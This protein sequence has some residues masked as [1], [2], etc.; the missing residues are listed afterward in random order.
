MKKLKYKK[1]KG[2][3]G[4]IVPLVLLVLTGAFLMIWL[5]PKGVGAS[6]SLGVRIA[7]TCLLG[8]IT[9]VFCWCIFWNY[10]VITDVSIICVS[11]PFTSRI[12]LENI[13]EIKER[14]GILS[15]FCLSINRLSIYTG[16][17][18]FK[19]FDVA[20]KEKEEFLDELSSKI[21]VTITRRK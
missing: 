14:I 16:K 21:N 6:D 7:S 8:I 10:Y 11:G 15:S 13:T 1:F 9:L 18:F 12:R 3:I 2:K 5:L 4:L 17:G 20:P 19:R